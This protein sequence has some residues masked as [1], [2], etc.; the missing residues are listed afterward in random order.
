MHK[1]TYFTKEGK[2]NTERTLDI[3]YEDLYRE[4]AGPHVMTDFAYYWY[5]GGVLHRDNGPAIIYHKNGIGETWRNGEYYG[6]VTLGRSFK[7]ET[8][9]I[10]SIN[11]KKDLK[12]FVY[13]TREGRYETNQYDL[14]PFDKLDRINGP[15]FIDRSTE[16]LVWYVSGKRHREKGPAVIRVGGKSGEHWLNGVYSTTSYFYNLSNMREAMREYFELEKDV[17]SE[18]VVVVHDAAYSSEQNK[19]FQKILDL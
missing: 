13:Y 1:Y 10:M 17:S 3:P 15:A 4:G 8:E 6:K 16:T 11:N 5:K 14:I 2:F 12:A 9:D 7:R 19:L 18:P